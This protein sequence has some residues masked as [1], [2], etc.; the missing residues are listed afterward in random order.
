MTANEKIEQLE[1]E[2]KLVKEAQAGFQSDIRSQLR[3]VLA[4][5]EYHHENQSKHKKNDI[6]DTVKEFL[7][8]AIQT[9]GTE[10][11]DGSSQTDHLERK[12][13]QVQA[14]FEKQGEA[15]ATQTE[16]P[17]KCDCEVQTTNQQESESLPP[18]VPAST[19]KQE[20][21]MPN[22]PSSI[23]Q[24]PAKKRKL[25]IT[26]SSSAAPRNLASIEVSL[27]IQPSDSG[28]R[29]GDRFSNELV[30]IEPSVDD[31]SAPQ[32]SLPQ[33]SIS[34]A[35][36]NPMI[37]EKVDVDDTTLNSEVYQIYCRHKEPK[38]AMKEI[39][40]LKHCW[41]FELAE[42]PFPSEENFKNMCE[43]VL[44][45]LWKLE[46]RLGD[47]KF[48]KIRKYVNEDITE[49]QLKKPDDKVDIMD[50]VDE[51]MSWIGIILPNRYEF[52]YIVNFE[53]GPGKSKWYR[54]ESS[55]INEG[56]TLA[57]LNVLGIN[58]SIISKLH[59]DHYLAKNSTK[60]EWLDFAKGLRLWKRS[61]KCLMNAPEGCLKGVLSDILLALL[62]FNRVSKLFNI[63]SCGI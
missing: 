21:A 61:M 18:L 20:I 28:V 1:K 43:T 53:Q 62:P 40:R 42:K 34:F 46:P 12:D 24:T 2:L 63:K 45:R 8:T 48:E 16:S 59:Y 26:I 4:R 47:S 25:S 58:D 14:H 31:S 15:I 17:E 50:F 10:T 6:I 35:A 56:R 60:V 32:N 52:W 41:G 33:Q 30:E 36:S 11:S 29:T 23:G 37:S 7:D 13:F 22:I 49:F 57:M 5:E 51:C 27:P 19:I 55:D 3:I 9:N 54:A 39:E 44:D 38:E